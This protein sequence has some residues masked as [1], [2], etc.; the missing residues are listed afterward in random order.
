MSES[1]RK[2]ASGAVASEAAAGGREPPEGRGIAPGSARFGWVFAAV[3]LIYLL[4]PLD[5]INA[6]SGWR[7]ALGYVAFAAFI[8]LFIGGIGYGRRLRIYDQPWPMWQRW[9]HLAALM[10]AMVAMIPAAG[11]RAIV[12]AAFISAFAAASLPRLWAVVTVLAL[13]AGAEISV[14]VV[15]GWTDRGVGLGVVLAAIAAGSFRLA[16]E[17]NKA[18]LAARDE[19]AEIAVE[20]ERSRIA[21]DL[22]DILG[23]SL[24]VITVKTELARRLLD[25]DVER[26][27]RELDDLEKLSRDALADVRATAMGVRGVSLVGEIAQARQALETAGID[28]VLPNAADDVPN[29]W[30]EVFAWAIRE[31]VTNVIRHSGAQRCVVEVGAHRLSIRDD[32]VGLPS[33]A[34]APGH[35]LAGLRHR[36]ELAGASMTTGAS[37]GGRGLEVIVE[38]PG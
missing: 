26:A 22:H 25:V 8:V 13:L 36:V 3:W 28:A 27:R 20:E 29:P 14:R 35:G 37:P 24:T 31:C 1:A 7:Q 32:G 6:S 11:D 16:F 10:A 30:R 19:L 17:R 38:V 9:L 33:G 18:L 23:H 34:I 12:G 15:D 2:A 4:A 5:A 21:R